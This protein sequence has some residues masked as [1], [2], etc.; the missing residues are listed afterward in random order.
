MGE[1][2]TF[3][4]MIAPVVIQVL[5]WIG[6]VFIVIAGLI[7]LFSGAF[8][9]GLAMIILGPIVVRVY[10]EVLLVFFRILDNL[11]EININTRK[12]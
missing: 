4:K 3:D 12:G 8:L 5:F 11:R 6:V 7:S 9:T 10:C 1:Y 2:L